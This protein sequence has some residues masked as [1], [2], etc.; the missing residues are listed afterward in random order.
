MDDSG[1]LPYKWVSTMFL[2][3]VFPETLSLTLTQKPYPQIQDDSW[4]IRD[5]VFVDYD[6]FVCTA[7]AAK[8]TMGNTD[9]LVEGGTAL[10]VPP[11]VTLQA[12]K[13]SA[14]N[15]EAVAQ[16]FE[17]RHQ[18][19]DMFDEF[20]WSPLVKFTRWPFVRGLLEAYSETARTPDAGSM[21]VGHA[22]FKALVLEFAREAWLS[23]SPASDPHHG[24]VFRMAREL[25]KGFRDEHAV[26]TV[27][28]NAPCSADYA[29]RLFR[30]QF[31]VTPARYHTRCR[32]R[33]AADL[34]VGGSSVKEAAHAVGYDDQLYFSRVFTKLQGMAPRAFQKQ[35]AG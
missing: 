35:G 14:S 27:L 19:A 28:T 5:F 17:L 16:H 34:L 18:G 7:G 33:L 23:D 9:Y 6:L 22:L 1:K 31:G 30:R 12:R 24:F 32:I 13:T 2:D 3:Q 29:G 20:L 21:L 11:R 10:L 8:F 26:E 4:S 15:F 25:E